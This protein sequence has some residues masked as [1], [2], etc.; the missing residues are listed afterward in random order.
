MIEKTYAKI[1]AEKRR[2][3]IEQEKHHPSIRNTHNRTAD[4]YVNRP[5]TS[6]IAMHR[7]G[8]RA[9]GRLGAGGSREMGRRNATYGWAAGPTSRGPA[10]G[11]I[12]TEIV[13][14]PRPQPWLLLLQRTSQKSPASYA[15]ANPRLK[16]DASAIT[17]SSRALTSNP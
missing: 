1:L 7:A 14:P 6:E 4:K 5:T 15:H 9:G 10:P 17:V 11:E 3:F 2:D 8:T 13:E 16:Q 12:V